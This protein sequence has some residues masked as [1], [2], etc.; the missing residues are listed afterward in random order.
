MTTEN[1]AVAPDWNPPYDAKDFF[2][3]RG[4]I[5]VGK[6][7]AS[8]P[9]SHPGTLKVRIEEWEPKRNEGRRR[10]GQRGVSLWW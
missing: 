4:C 7:E 8:T 3:N 10:F 9:P 2:R 6:L 5:V 1:T